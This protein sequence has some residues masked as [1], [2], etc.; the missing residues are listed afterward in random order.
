MFAIRMNVLQIHTHNKLVVVCWRC[1]FQPGLYI[2]DIERLSAL[3]IFNVVSNAFKCVI[4]FGIFFHSLVLLLLFFPAC[5]SH[6]LSLQVEWKKAKRKNFFIFFQY[7]AFCILISENVLAHFTQICKCLCIF[8]SSLAL[9][10]LFNIQRMFYWAHFGCNK[11]GFMIAIFSFFFVF[12]LH[13]FSLSEQ[14]KRSNSWHC[15]M[16]CHITLA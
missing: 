9:S 12:F 5:L 10:V 1:A 4:K 3:P 7:S 13:L 8:S 15:Q 14:F 6:A 2:Y 16:K 11:F